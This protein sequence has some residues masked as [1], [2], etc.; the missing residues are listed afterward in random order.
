[1]Y[2]LDLELPSPE[3]ITIAVSSTLKTRFSTLVWISTFLV[4]WISAI[5]VMATTGIE[6]F[7]DTATS[8]APG[9]SFTYCTTSTMV[10]TVT[11]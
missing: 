10:V 11:A 1:M 4:S 3:S 5:S 7:V 8:S 2:L 6:S 9:S